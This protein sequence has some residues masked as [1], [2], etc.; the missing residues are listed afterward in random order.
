MPRYKFTIEY[1]GGQYAGWQKQ[2][3]CT[4]VQ[5]ELLYAAQELTGQKEI[6]IQGAGRTDSGVHATAQVAHIDIKKDMNTYNV[7]QG[8]NYHLFHRKN[9]AGK[10]EPYMQN[11]IAVTHVEKVDDEFHAR[12]SATKRYYLYRIINRQ[13]RL[14][15]DIG[16]AWQVSDDLDIDAMH[17]AA[18]HLVGHH[19]FSSFRDS[20]CQ[21]KSPIKTME[22]LEIQIHGDDIYLHASARSFLHHQIRIITGTLVDVGK[23]RIKADDIP[24]IL[25]A[26]KREAAGQTA[27]ADGLYLTGVDYK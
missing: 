8:L 5:G 17:K 27:P 1:D 3:D 18:A 22:R 25:E 12:F 10:L 4:T 14:G 6:A 15:L 16:R 19:D 21:A 13:A 7:M 26:K 9:V 23:G 20:L 11:R 24:K 2:D